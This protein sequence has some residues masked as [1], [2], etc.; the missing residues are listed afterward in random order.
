MLYFKTLR[1]TAWFFFFW[2][3]PIAAAAHEPNPQDS[4]WTA[5]TSHCGK[6]Y[7]GQMVSN[8]PSDA[9]MRD[10]AMVMH[11]RECSEGQVKVPFHVQRTD[12]SWDRSRTWIFSRPKGQGSGAIR[13]KHDHRHEDGKP[14]TMTLYGGDTVTP[15]S[16]TTQEFPADAESIALFKSEGRAASIFNVWRVEV[17]PANQSKGRFAYRLLRPAPHT[18]NFHVEFDL[19]KEVSA[20]PAPWGSH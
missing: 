17:T 9:E 15:G 11:V 10:V 14:D 1:L 13:L 16:A 7:R 3:L 19:T 2:Q 5:L 20:P 8:E 6:A 4:F 18:R 12:G